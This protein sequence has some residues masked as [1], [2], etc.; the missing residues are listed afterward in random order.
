MIVYFGMVWP[1]HLCNSREMFV[2][3]LI[4]DIH[5]NRNKMRKQVEVSIERPLSAVPLDF[6]GRKVNIICMPEFKYL[7]IMTHKISYLE[8]NW[9]L[10]LT[11]EIKQNINKWKNTQKCSDAILRYGKQSAI[12][13][14]ILALYL[15]KNSRL[16]T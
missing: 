15:Y 11:I 6:W 14:P 4:T 1:S 12:C 8:T 5:W 3:K 10:L 7:F 16:L 13:T 9:N 2:G